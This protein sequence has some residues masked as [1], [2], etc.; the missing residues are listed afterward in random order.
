MWYI[1]TANRVLTLMKTKAIVKWVIIIPSVL[2]VGYGSV[3]L[4]RQS[5]QPRRGEE[6]AIQGRQH[7]A[8]GTAHPS[9]NS[10]PPTSG[11]HY[12]EPASWGVYQTELS[13]EQ[14]IHNLE[15]GGIWISYKEI[16]VDTKAK[17]EDLAKRF[18]S[19]VIITPRAS[20]DAKIVLAS[21]GRLE[22]LEVFDEAEILAFIKANKNKSPEP[23]AR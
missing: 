14:V 5:Q 2:V 20:N 7:I 21:W 18:P 4:A 6:F 15:H 3:F 19:S 1:I 16:D 17:L 13:D 12:T 10:N 11:W 8:I 9:Y 23:I 22:Q